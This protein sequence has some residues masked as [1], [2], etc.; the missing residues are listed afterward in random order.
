MYDPQSSRCFQIVP[1]ELSWT[2]ARQQ[3]SDRGGDLA[4]VRSDTLCNLLRQKVTQ[5][6]YLALVF[7]CDVFAFIMYVYSVSYYYIIVSFPQTKTEK[8]IFLEVLM[9]SYYYGCSQCINVYIDR[10]HYSYC[11]IRRDPD[12]RKLAKETL[13]QTSNTQN[14]CWTFNHWQKKNHKVWMGV[15]KLC[16][17]CHLWHCVCMCVHMRLFSILSYLMGWSVPHWFLSLFHFIYFY[18]F[19]FIF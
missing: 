16:F 4:I 1:G 11:I 3:C 6:V 14:R 8:R 5:W 19:W 15:W 12:C 7:L 10:C 9:Y 2:D 13:W 17:S 18:W